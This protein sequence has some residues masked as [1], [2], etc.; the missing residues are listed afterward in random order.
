MAP[1]TVQ[2]LADCFITATATSSGG[3]G[4]DAVRHMGLEEHESDRAVQEAMGIA[5]RTPG[6]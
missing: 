4:D 3:G 1:A 5:Y 2:H 6:D